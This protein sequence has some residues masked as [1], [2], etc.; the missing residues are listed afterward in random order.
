MKAFQKLIVIALACLLIV[1][2]AKTTAYAA[3]GTI[4]LSDP[5]A[6]A[7]E[8]VAVTVKVTATGSD[9]IKSVD[10]EL[11]YD[12]EALEFENSTSATGDSGT[13]KLSGTADSAIKTFT[14][15]FKALKSSTSSIKITSYDVKDSNDAAIEMSKVGSSTV[16]ISGDGAALDSTESVEAEGETAEQTDVQTEEEKIVTPPG[17]N[18]EVEIAGTPFYAC[19]ITQDIIPEGFEYIGYM[20]NGVAVDAVMKDSII[21]F[22][23]NQKGEAPYVFYVYD[24]E[25]D[26]FSVYAPVTPYFEYVVVSLEEGVTIPDGFA[27]TEVSV[28]GVAVTA[29]QSSESS[30]F[31]LLYLMNSEGTKGLYRYDVVEKTVQRY[32]NIATGETLET[33]DSYQTMYAELNSKYNADIQGRM[34]LVYALIIISVILLFAVI[35]LIFR[36]SDK[37]HAALDDEEDFDEEEKSFSEDDSDYGIIGQDDDEDYEDDYE[38]DYE[39]KLSRKEKKEL[40]KAAKLEKKEQAKKEKVK[41]AQKYEEEEEL[42]NSEDDFDDSDDFEMQIFDLDDKK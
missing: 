16:T 21:L 19:K 34:K 6:Q 25:T 14:L 5:T 40:K 22:Y 9:T 17:K 35:N 26:G 29:W 37:R 13:I 2:L 10:M 3:T 33:A 11:S 28:G 41:K 31:Y 18:V 20:Y 38:D 24:A 32:Y 1:P 23:L 42:E 30:E 36:L 15:N 7:G 12:K 27:E 39:E 8:S 4:S